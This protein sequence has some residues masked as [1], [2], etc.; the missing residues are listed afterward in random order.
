MRD[1]GTLGGRHSKAYGI[2]DVG[3]VVGYS[4]NAAGETHAFLWDPATEQM[5]DLGT[6]GGDR[7][8]A[9]CINDGGQIAGLT[10]TA[11]GD[12]HACTWLAGEHPPK[13]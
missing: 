6:L 7:S 12:Y 9:N 8:Y 2:N 11:A 10:V 5:V 1:L 3:Q 13:H 4:A